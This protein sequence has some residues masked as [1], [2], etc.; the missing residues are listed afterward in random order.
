MRQPRR[1]R[2]RCPAVTQVDIRLKCNSVIAVLL[3]S[4]AAGPLRLLTVDDTPESVDPKQVRV[5]S[6]D[7]S[8]GL[9]TVVSFEDGHGGT[10]VS[11]LAKANRTRDK[12]KIDALIAGI[13]SQARRARLFR[14][15]FG[16]RPPAPGSQR[17]M[18][19]EAR[20]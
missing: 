9:C 5:L 6:G 19:P 18:R 12:A 14:G 15:H 1:C 11:V 13:E 3:V 16:F 4:L 8:R 20:A 17:A 10:Q 2:V 7:G